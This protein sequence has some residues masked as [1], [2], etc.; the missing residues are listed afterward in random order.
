MSILEK[1]LKTKQTECL[2]LKTLESDLKAKLNGLPAPKN[3][4]RSLLSSQEPAIIAEVK[5]ASPSKGVIL[6]DFDH[7]KI[8]KKYESDGAACISVLTDKDYFQGDLNFLKEIDAECSI[9]ALRKDFIIDPL[10]I[11]EARVSGADAV[12]LIAAALDTEKLCSL[13]QESLRLNLDVLLEVHNQDEM[14]SAF[15]AL[16][17]LTLKH[18]IPDFSDRVLLGINNR[19]LSTFETSLGVTKTLIANNQQKISDLSL[20]VVSE[21]GI[22]EPSDIAELSEAGAKGFL[23]G[24]SLMREPDLLK[25]L[26]ETCQENSNLEDGKDSG[27]E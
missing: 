3:F 14:D 10:Q 17:Q 21:S 15:E 1:I 9:P 7:I 11:L 5:K 19:N 26:I 24:E 8:A 25:R 2:E 6:E 18:A 20:A 16:E 27:R 12:L 4:V 13:L 23:I 22:F